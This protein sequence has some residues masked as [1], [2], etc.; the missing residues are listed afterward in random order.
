MESYI[1][2]DLPKPLEKLIYI[3]GSTDTGPE[4]SIDKWMKQNLSMHKQNY[5]DKMLFFFKSKAH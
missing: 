4:E 2:D 3:Y 5:S 1:P